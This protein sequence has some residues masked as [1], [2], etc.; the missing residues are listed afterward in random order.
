VEGSPRAMLATARPSCSCSLTAIIITRHDS[1]GSNS[2]HWRREW[3]I[4]PYSPGSTHMYLSPLD[5][6]VPSNGIG[7]AIFAEHTVVTSIYAVPAKWTKK[8]LNSC[9]RNSNTTTSCMHSAGGLLKSDSAFNI[10][11]HTVYCKKD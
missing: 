9:Y 3:I 10:N 4:Q 5:P 7:S 6:R 8:M 11:T 2:P 1:D